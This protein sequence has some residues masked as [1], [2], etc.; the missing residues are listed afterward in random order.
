VPLTEL[1][2]RARHHPAML[3]WWNEYTSVNQADLA[4]DTYR[5]IRKN[6][7]NHPVLYMLAWAGA[8]SD[9]Y[10]VYGYPILNPLLPDDSIT[11]IDE[12]I[13]QPAF[14]AAREEGVGKQVW[15]VSQ[16]FDYRLDSNRGEIVTLEGGFRPSREEIRAMNYFALTKGVKGLAFYAPGGEIPGTEYT[17]DVAI[18]PRQWTEVLTVASELR[19]LTPTLAAGTRAQTVELEQPEEGIHFIELVHDAVHTLIAVNA[20]PSMVL[21]TWRFDHPQRPNVLFED[22]VPQSAS[23]NFTDLFHPL[24]V[25]IY[26]WPSPA[27]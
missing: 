8:F 12:L 20:K 21:A 24:Q 22:R 18:Y 5:L 17:D 11:S 19:H 2:E 6:D 13:L 1:V 16:A 7:P 25:H 23:L 15:F 3:G 10:F 4:R 14:Q 27:D 9:G 26:Q